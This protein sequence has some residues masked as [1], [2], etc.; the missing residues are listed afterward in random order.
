LWSGEVSE[1]ADRYAGVSGNTRSS[2]A[3]YL[4]AGLKTVA[5]KTAV[6]VNDAAR[7]ARPDLFG[8]SL[9]APGLVQ[10]ADA[11]AP[12]SVPSQAP[13]HTSAAPATPGR[14]SVVTTPPRAKVYLGDAD[15]GLS[16]LDLELAPDIYALRVVLDGYK[17]TTEKVSVRRAALTEVEIRLER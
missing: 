2:I 3:E 5:D 6:Q 17:T 7:R 1:I 10:R 14:L 8:Q 11:P 15:W 13:G 4:G 16:P 9:P 12:V